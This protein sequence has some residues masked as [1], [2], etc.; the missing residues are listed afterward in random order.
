MRQIIP[1]PF[2]FSTK[3][4]G[5]EGNVAAICLGPKITDVEFKRDSR[6]DS[7]MDPSGQEHS[8]ILRDLGQDDESPGQLLDNKIWAM[9]RQDSERMLVDPPPMPAFTA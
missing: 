4:P 1:R 2:R 8:G 9:G 3:R 6:P 7:D 5:V